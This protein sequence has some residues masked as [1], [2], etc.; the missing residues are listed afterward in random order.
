MKETVELDRLDALRLRTIIQILD[1]RQV[2]K[3]VLCKGRVHEWD[4]DVLG[5]LKSL[6]EVLDN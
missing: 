1:G 3:C 6:N 4:C 2:G 5:A